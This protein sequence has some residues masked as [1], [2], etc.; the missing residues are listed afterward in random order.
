MSNKSRSILAILSTDIVGYTKATEQDESH[1]FSLIA[2]HR[3][4][5]PK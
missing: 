3:D 2:K 4:I 1:A 5:V